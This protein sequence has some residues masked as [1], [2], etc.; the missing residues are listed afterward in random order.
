MPNRLEGLSETVKWRLMTDAAKRGA[1]AAGYEM[2]RVPG[3]GLSN[4]W[5]ITKDGETR[6]AAIRTTRDR[7]FAFPPQNKGTKWK[8]LDDVEVVIVASVDSKDE[9]E[10]VEVF[11]FPADDVRKHFQAA[12]NARTQA[13]QE[14]REDFGMWISLQKDNRGI[15]ASVG[16]GLADKYKMVKKFAIEDL[17]PS[18]GSDDSLDEDADDVEAL[19]SMAPAETQPATIGEVLAWARQRVADLAGVKIEAV[20]LDLKVEY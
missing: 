19:T 9:P 2:K 6:K 11:I 8:T 20:K 4:I 18:T 13:G 16:S 14:V 7:W 15:P 1:M 3:R 5:F 12:Y 10:N 17:I